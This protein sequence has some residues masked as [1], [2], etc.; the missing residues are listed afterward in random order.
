MAL[1]IVG[2]SLIAYEENS[3]VKYIFG[4][5]N[6][7]GGLSLDLFKISGEKPYNLNERT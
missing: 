7:K 4:G 5:H 2:N 3:V 1:N 6:S